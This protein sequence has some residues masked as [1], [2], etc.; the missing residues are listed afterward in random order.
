VGRWWTRRFLT[1][2]GEILSECGASSTSLIPF[3]AVDVM[4]WTAC[5]GGLCRADFWRERGNARGFRRKMA[6]LFLYSDP[7]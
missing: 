2:L 4:R 3:F 1:Y 6:Y 7:E 5:G